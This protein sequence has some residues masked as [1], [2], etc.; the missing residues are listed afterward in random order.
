MPETKGSLFI[1]AGPPGAGKTTLATLL[2]EGAAR[3][4]VHLHTDS[5]YVAIRT[6][7]VAPYLP[8]AAQQNEVVIGV[9][10]EAACGYARGGYDVILDGV[11]GPWFMSPFE[12]ARDREQ[13]TLNYVVLR[14]SLS[15]TL[16]RA[17]AREGRALKEVDPITGLYRAFADLGPLEAHALDTTGQEAVE[18]IALLRSGFAD[19]RF[20]LN[21]S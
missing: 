20:R 7:Y 8:G 14:P 1:L 9:I 16:A 15:E 19:G 12:A 6:G 2:A 3:P 13:L 10:V 11:I 5:F 17:G 21:K 4:T 18:T